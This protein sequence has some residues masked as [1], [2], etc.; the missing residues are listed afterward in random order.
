MWQG[1]KRRMRPWS[2]AWITL[3]WNVIYGEFSWGNTIA[4]FLLGLVIV[5]GLPLP[6]IPV[7]A[8]GIR[9]LPLLQLLLAFGVDL[10]VS[11]A[12]VAWLAVRPADQPPSAIIEVPMR[13][14]EDMVFAIAVALLNLTPGGT[15]TDMD[16]ANRK[17]T[18]HILDGRSTKAIEAAER[19]VAKLE[20]QLITIFEKEVSA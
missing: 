12:R 9:W 5:L 4:G 17:L 16:I 6:Q 19:D 7:S 13:V 8:L 2:L 10:V 15:V 14:Q 20:R 1:V 3:M 11:S 18:M